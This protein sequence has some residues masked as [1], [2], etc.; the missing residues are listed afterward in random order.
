MERCF[1][2]ARHAG[3]VTSGITSTCRRLFP[4]LAP[5]TLI[6]K[7]S[8]SMNSNRTVR[9]GLAAFLLFSLS[10]VAATIKDKSGAVHEGKIHGTIVLKADERETQ[11]EQDPSK[12]VYWAS[13]T[14]INGSDIAA[15]DAK[16][17]HL[18]SGQPVGRFDV[19]QEDAPL[20]DADVVR[21]S[22]KIPPGP[23]GAATTKAAGTVTRVEYH[24]K[25]PSRDTVVGEY[26]ADGEKSEVR[27]VIEIETAKGVVKVPVADLAPIAAE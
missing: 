3:R 11:S 22:V 16:G 14:V 17:I 21:T 20:D 7:T 24:G 1:Q 27:H 10:A 18:G 6:F 9:G 5:D 25:S 19:K 2:I 23:F 12:T 13:Y 4:Y 26:R 8:L 15:I